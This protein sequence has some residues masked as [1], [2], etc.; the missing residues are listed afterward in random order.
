MDAVFLDYLSGKVGGIMPHP[1]KKGTQLL[2][3]NE[4]SKNSGAL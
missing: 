2:E 3:S 1:K 4:N